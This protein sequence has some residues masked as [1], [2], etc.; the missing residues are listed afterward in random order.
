MRHEV[1]TGDLLICNTF[2]YSILAHLGMMTQLH[3]AFMC[4]TRQVTFL[5]VQVYC[6]WMSH[7]TLRND[8]SRHTCMTWLIHVCDMTHSCVWHD[9]HE[10]VMLLMKLCVPWLTCLATWYSN[11]RTTHVCDIHHSF[12]RH[13]SM[14]VTWFIH[15]CDMTHSCVWHDSFM[16]VTW[17]IHVCDM[18]HSCAWHESFMC[19]T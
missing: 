3:D 19:V 16:C 17:L 2:T 18:T 10:C 7:V 5:S 15:V 9:T 6:M 13:D 4:M 12:V 14:Q 1:V 8:E 11:C